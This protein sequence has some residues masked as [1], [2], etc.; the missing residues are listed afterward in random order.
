MLHMSL[1]SASM[2]VSATNY[3][4]DSLVGILA[5]A[6]GSMVRSEIALSTMSSMVRV[7][8]NN[9]ITITVRYEPLLSFESKIVW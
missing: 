6:L 3:E 2:A 4:H 9:G 7:L 1:S 8:R 5:V